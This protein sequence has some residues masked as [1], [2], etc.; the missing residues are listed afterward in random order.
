MIT[1][2]EAKRDDHTWAIKLLVTSVRGSIRE[3]RPYNHVTSNLHAPSV[4]VVRRPGSAS[5][6]DRLKQIK[7]SLLIIDIVF[8]GAGISSKVDTAFN[9]LHRVRLIVNGIECLAL[10]NASD[11]QSSAMYGKTCA[12]D[13]WHR[14][15][16]G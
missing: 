9:T 13:R 15:Y 12:A 11:K 1:V 16:L 6:R 5:S 2:V 7:N 8:A 10:T 14:S 4:A 3:A